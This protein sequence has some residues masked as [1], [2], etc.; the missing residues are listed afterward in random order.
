MLDRV[1]L[2]I[3]ALLQEDCT[4]PVAEIGKRVGPVHNPLLAAYPEA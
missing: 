2:E 4:L 1:D 3:L